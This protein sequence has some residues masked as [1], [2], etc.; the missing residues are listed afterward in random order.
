MPEEL[1]DFFQE[2]ESINQSFLFYRLYFNPS[3]VLGDKQ[4]YNESEKEYYNLPNY[5]DL[6]MNNNLTRFLDLALKEDSFCEK[7]DVQMYRKLNFFLY[8]SVDFKKYHKYQNALLPLFSGKI[9]MKDF[10]EKYGLS[11]WDI[12]W[13]GLFGLYDKYKSLFEHQ[14]SK[15]QV[16]NYDEQMADSVRRWL[17]LHGQILQEKTEIKQRD[18]KC[19]LQRILKDDYLGDCDDIYLYVYQLRSIHNDPRIIGESLNHE[20][21][22]FLVCENKF[23]DI[24]EQLLSQGEICGC[25]LTNAID[26]IDLGIKIKNY[27]YPRAVLLRKRIGNEQVNVFDIKRAQK[28]LS[29]LSLLKLSQE[30]IVQSS[31]SNIHSIIH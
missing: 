2:M 26:I 18:K 22:D 14:Y 27:T 1:R 19:T 12:E 31:K 16:D 28:I 13:I 21:V 17:N 10:Y 20:V 6:M 24:T 25:A 7:L 8:D 9:S 4:D 15:E 29:E 11:K 23:L 5:Y 30:R 3:S